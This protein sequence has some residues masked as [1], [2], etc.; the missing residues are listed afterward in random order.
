MESALELVEDQHFQAVEV[1]QSFHR[2]ARTVREQ[3]V[4]GECLG[5]LDDLGEHIQASV[6]Y[7][8]YIYRHPEEWDTYM[9]EREKAGLESL[10]RG[11][12]SCW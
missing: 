2:L 5:L 12:E 8:H 4:T 3:L 6:C 1:I 10:V 9:D 11:R 7:S